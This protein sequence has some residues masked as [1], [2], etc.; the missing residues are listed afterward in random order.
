MEF[1]IYAIVAIIATILA[2]LTVEFTVG[3]LSILSAHPRAKAVVDIILFFGIYFGCLAGYNAYNAKDQIEIS[4]KDTIRVIFNRQNI[5]VN[6]IEVEGK[7]DTS[8][9]FKVF[10]TASIDDSTARIYYC[11]SVKVDK[12]VV[13]SCNANK[14]LL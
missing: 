13:T 5:L 6:A 11:K 14:T 7:N 2:G 1:V 10:T 3:K 9:M 12:N 4:S 8:I